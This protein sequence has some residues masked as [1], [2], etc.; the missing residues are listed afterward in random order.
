[1]ISEEAL[2]EALRRK[3]P[4]IPGSNPGRRTPLLNIC[5]KKEAL[6]SGAFILLMGNST[7]I[8]DILD[9]LEDSLC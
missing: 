1:M 5:L 3:K 4:E 6:K 8:H 2:Q 9:F 7:W